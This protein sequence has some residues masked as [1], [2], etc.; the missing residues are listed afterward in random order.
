MVAKE[1]G[2]SLRSLI[3]RVVRGLGIEVT[4]EEI[5]GKRDRTA[6]EWMK[7]GT[8]KLINCKI[9]EIRRIMSPATP[10]I[11]LSRETPHPKVL[12]SLISIMQNS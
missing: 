10:E 4:E 7:Y 8:H 1:R 9:Q 11:S 5:R 12:H 6:H 2:A 3:L